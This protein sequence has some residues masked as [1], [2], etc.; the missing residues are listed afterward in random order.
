MFSCCDGAAEDADVGR[1]LGGRVRVEVVGI[2]FRLFQYFA[3]FLDRFGV[4]LF[5]DQRFASFESLQ[6]RA[7]WITKDSFLRDFA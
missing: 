3:K 7:R 4:T 5:F 1:A 2:V 6:Q